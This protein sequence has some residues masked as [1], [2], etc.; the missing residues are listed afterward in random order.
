MFYIFLDLPPRVRHCANGP[1]KESRVR[2]ELFPSVGG[3]K[4]A[5]QGAVVMYYSDTNT[6]IDFKKKKK[7]WATI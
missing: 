3:E 4:R 2:L 7:T 5:G 1:G 6:T